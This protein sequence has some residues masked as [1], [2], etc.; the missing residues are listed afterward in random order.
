[1]GKRRHIT[2]RGQNSCQ[3]QAQGFT[4]DQQSKLYIKGG[5][6]YQSNIDRLDTRECSHSSNSYHPAILHILPL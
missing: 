3:E 1:M 6:I 4:V 5:W 2:Q